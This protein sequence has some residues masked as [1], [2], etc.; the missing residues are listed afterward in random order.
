MFTGEDPG[1]WEERGVGVG[2]RS[3]TPRTTLSRG[4]RP[5]SLPPWQSESETHGSKF[6]WV[7]FRETRVECPILLHQTVDDLYDRSRLGLD[8]SVSFPPYKQPGQWDKTVQSVPGRESPVEICVSCLRFSI[9][10]V[11][12]VRPDP[13][14]APDRPLSVFWGVIKRVME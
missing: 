13:W 4:G 14:C 9:G 5:M 8:T 12:D 2:V 7:E 3:G 6:E 10:R 11:L 1:V